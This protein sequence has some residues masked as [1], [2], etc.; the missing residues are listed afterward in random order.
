MG[1]GGS[2]S[3]MQVV[4]LEEPDL[5]HT[6]GEFY[7]S[8]TENLSL[9]NGTPHGNKS[10]HHSTQNTAE[11]GGAFIILLGS[12]RVNDIVISF[13]FKRNFKHNRMNPL[14]CR[15]VVSIEMVSATLC[16]LITN[17]IFVCLIHF[18]WL[19]FKFHIRNKHNIYFLF[20]YF[21]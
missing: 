19:V 20:T 5:K 21:N 8:D 6:N 10:S 1:C 15:V 4:S 18:S 17:V 7:N 3:T 12:A 13:Y 9:S 16:S 2:K 11:H 14:K